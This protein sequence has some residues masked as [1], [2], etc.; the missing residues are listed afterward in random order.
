MH[1]LKFGG[2]SLANADRI[3]RVKDII[4]QEKSSDQGIL[5]I[6]SAFGGVTDLLLDT[7]DQAIGHESDHK[8]SLAALVDRISEISLQLIPDS[9]TTVINGL[10]ALITELENILFGIS[11]VHE[12]TDRI[13]DHVVSFGERISAMVINAY[14]LDQDISSQYVDARDFIKTD[15]QHGCARV[16]FDLSYRLISDTFKTFNDVGIVTGFIGSDKN[17][18]ITTTLGRG[19]SDYTA[20]IFAGALDVG[21]LQIW[22]DVNGVLSADPR[23]VKKAYTIESLSYMEALELSH[24]GAKV[25]YAPTVRPIREKGIPLRIKNTFEPRHPGTIISAEKSNNASTIAGVTSIDSISLI[26]LEG[27]GMQGISGIAHRFFKALAEGQ[28]NVIMITQASSEQSITIATKSEESE[29]AVSLINNAFGFEI[30]RGLVDKAQ[31]MNGLSL[32]AMVG[33][34]MKEKPGVAGRLFECLGRNGINVEAI[35]QGSSELNI[36]FAVASRDAVKSLNA[37]HDNFF[38]SSYKTVPLYIVGTGLVGKKLIQLIVQN[39]ESIKARHGLELQINGLSNSRKMLLSNEGLALSAEITEQL[40]GSDSPASL[41]RFVE[42]MVD[43]NLSDSVF[44]DNTAGSETVAYYKNILDKS[45]AIS[46]P[47]KV[48]LSSEMELYKQLKHTARHKNTS[49]N[50][51][52]NVGAGLPVISTLQGLVSSGDRI[53]RIEAVLS[54]SLSYIFNNYS[55]SDNFSVVVKKAKDQ[56]YTEPDPRD[57]LSGKDARRKLL[58]LARDAGYAIE[59]EDIDIAPCVPDELLEGGDISNFF[60]L[61]EKQDKAMKEHLLQ[62]TKN[63]ERLRFI[64]RFSDGKGHIS[65]ES[66]DDK[67]PFF[68]L[69]GSDNMIAFYTE[70]YNKSPLIVQGPGAGADVT[71]AGVL[72]EIININKR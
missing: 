38:L 51:E 7:I 29:L 13:K 52:T 56:G 34:N 20:A 58:I 31:A 50:Y 71:A 4:Q 44:V 60:H 46:T 12:A 23:K 72:S 36:S 2:S 54:G 16:D 59:M 19:G 30:E 33:E 25:L 43:S 8:S 66:V 57:D 42:F 47:N 68:N 63:K 65:L 32:I 6:V 37:I 3:T 5:V 70:R 67:S 61:L 35:A 18:G 9:K 53:E 22:T 11:L 39:Q 14:L 28:V 26:T 27:P 64:A 62:S 21:E 49:I 55:S 15:N 10:T 41:D 1:I 69:S 48:A 40:D 45:I 24:F 17:T